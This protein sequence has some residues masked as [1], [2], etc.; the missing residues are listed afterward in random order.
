[1]S[2][3][4]GNV[5]GLQIVIISEVLVWGNVLGASGKHPARNLC[6]EVF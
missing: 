6:W 3:S 5:G 4:G 2:A 1:M